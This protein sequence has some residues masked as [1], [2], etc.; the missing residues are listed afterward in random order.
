MRQLSLDIQIASSAQN[1]PDE[2]KFDHWLAA[3][4]DQRQEPSEV[5][6]RI[7]DPEEMQTL[8]FQ[9]R[10]KDK[11]TNV[12]SFPA[13]FPEELDLPLLGDIV[14]CA[15]IIEQEA[16]EQGKTTEAHWAHMLIHGTLHLLGY[17]HI[18]EKDA[19]EMEALEA[20]I[21]NKLDYPNPYEEE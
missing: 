9:Y 4:L 8:N 3:A 21:L 5:S 13:E 7:V 1:I 20:Q 14:I 6:L 2:A 12:L 10:Q 16:Q 17:D 11:P 19:Q 18:E 15:P